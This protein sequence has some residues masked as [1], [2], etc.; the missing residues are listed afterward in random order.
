MC[1]LAFIPIL[2][3]TTLL[4]H[5]ALSVFFDIEIKPQEVL[6][7][8]QQ[9]EGAIRYIYILTAI[10]S[11]PFFEELFLEACSF[12]RSPPVLDSR[13]DASAQRCSLL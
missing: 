2:A 7:T 8:I 13:A 9:S 11:G 10:F 6:S 1:Y 4:Y 5:T 12:P 3:L